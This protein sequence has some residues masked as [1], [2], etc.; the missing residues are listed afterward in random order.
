MKHNILKY[1]LILFFPELLLPSGS[2]TREESGLDLNAGVDVLAFSI[3]DYAGEADKKSAVISVPVPAGL[4]PSAMT[5]TVLEL[6]EGAEASLEVGDV[7]DFTLPRALIVTNGDVRMEYSI[8]LRY[9][10]AII[11]SFVLGGFTGIIDDASG[12]IVV[13]VPAGTDLT[14]MVPE[15][16]VNDGATVTPESGLAMDF[17]EDVTFKVTYKTAEKI[18]TVHVNA[19]NAPSAVFAGLAASFD[20]LAPEEK[21]AASWML[22]NVENS[23]YA[24]FG[25]IAAG[26]VD[27]SRCE[28]VWWHY[29]D[30]EGNFNESVFNE[31]A[32]DAVS[33]ASVLKEL[34]NGGTG[35]VL[36]RYATLYAA[37]LD[38]TLDGAVPNNCWGS[39]EDGGEVTSASWSFDIA[40]G[41][42]GHP[43]YSGLLFDEGEPDKVY[44]CDTGYRISNSTAQ[45]FIGGWSAYQDLSSWSSAHGATA[46]SV[47][48]ND[49]QEVTV[50]IWE[51]TPDGSRGKVICIGSGCYDWYSAEGDMS[52][53]RCYHGN[54]AGLTLNA[55][56]YAAKK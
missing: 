24:S 55:I 49:S 2:C 10:E 40:D 12:R 21:A 35:F 27:L 50:P 34:L 17:S 36:T 51:Y 19:T 48:V 43:L 47:N 23:V 54:V 39:P 16:T 13:N 30:D 33:A 22:A 53:D 3:D 15:I 14:S 11:E 1:I 38:V 52:A 18:Y 37:D 42:T 25:D 41:Q 5:V 32:A 28:V 29:H 26:V 20:Q 9:D 44:T 46:L 31:K 45:W 8:V 4:D 7:I 6:S 56:N